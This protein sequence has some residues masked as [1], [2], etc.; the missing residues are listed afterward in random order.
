MG[1]AAYMSPEQARGLTVDKRT[2]IWAFG[3]VLFEML[4]GRAAFAGETVTDTLAAIL[5]RE[6]DWMGLPAAAPP[7]AGRLLRLCLDKDP[8]Q[9]LR[10][11]G[12]ARVEL[13]RPAAEPQRPSRPTYL[14][15]ALMLTLL[16]LAAGTGLFYAAR[17]S[18]AVTSPAEYTPITNFTDSAVA[19]SL[20]PDGRMVTFIRSGGSAA[21]RLPDEGEPFASRGQIYVKLLPNGE[22]VQL[23]N[24]STSQ[25]A[26]VFTPDGSR[27]A[28]TRT[29]PGHWDT[30]T[31]PVL[32]GPPA[33]FCPT[34]PD[35]GQQLGLEPMQ[36]RCQRRTPIPPRRRSDQTKRRIGRETLRI[37]EVFIARQAAVHRLPQEIG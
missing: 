5:D 14:A 11:I 17:R 35:M 26:P 19:P 24:D 9:R 25:S 37:V 34:P 7:A 6:P 32:G 13:E 10:D 30:W 33:R 12:D 3:C 22:S 2:D 36:R 1:T 20:S 18:G 29:T 8:R 27:I 4:T 21:H 31:V 28:Y 16:V 23:T 15:V